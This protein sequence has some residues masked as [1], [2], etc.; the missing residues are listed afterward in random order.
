MSDL[1][2]HRNTITSLVVVAALL[3]GFTLGRVTSGGR[4]SSADEGASTTAVRSSASI[5]AS[6]ASSSAASAS[7]NTAAATTSAAEA[8]TAAEAAASDA[9][10]SA[11]SAGTESSGSAGTGAPDHS[12]LNRSDLVDAADADYSSSTSASSGSSQTQTIT[13]EAQTDIPT[14]ETTVDPSEIENVTIAEAPLPDGVASTLYA[15]TGGEALFQVVVLGDSQFA[16]FTDQGGLGY[17]LSQ[18]MHANVYNLAIGGKTAT[19]DPKDTGTDPNAWT[20]TCG[21]GMVKAVCGLADANHVFSGWDYQLNVFNSCDFSKTDIFVL[22]FGVND[23][24]AKRAMSNQD[25]LG[26]WY[27]VFGAFE[28]MVLDI[29]NTYPNAQIMICTPT[30]AQFWQAGTGAFLGDSNIV[31]NGYGTLF[32]YAETISH[33]AGG[34]SNTTTVNEYENA[35]INSYTAKDDLLDGI[36]LTNAGRIKY[37]NLLARVALRSQGYDIGEGVDPDTVDWISQTPYSQ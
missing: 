5:A 35:N 19:V 1:K 24:L 17:L 7:S 29:R 10:A 23:Y 22:E 33:P 37:A 8:G 9:A 36:H 11:S 32:N 18:K 4:N 21:V 26:N 34:H 31:N 25:D 27:T 6:E 12:D 28:T 30:Y 3:A 2:N 20:E 16:N 14:E 13:H 15:K